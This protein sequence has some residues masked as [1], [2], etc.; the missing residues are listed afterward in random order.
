MFQLNN[1]HSTNLMKYCENKNQNVLIVSVPKVGME[2]CQVAGT[3]DLRMAITLLEKEIAKRE[4]KDGMNW[5]KGNL[6]DI[7]KLPMELKY[8]M[9]KANLLKKYAGQVLQ[10]FTKPYGLRMGQGQFPGWVVKVDR[11]RFSLT[12]PYLYGVEES[13]FSLS[14]I[15][16]WN[17]LNGVPSFANGNAAAIKKNSGVCSHLG[18][19]KIFVELGFVAI[20]KIQMIF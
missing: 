10:W 5:V 7:P 17:D 6:E 15:I 20:N 12:D 11:A 9:S 18:F 2:E 19:I 13:E 8:L 1:I 16:E 14:D 4:A 3:M